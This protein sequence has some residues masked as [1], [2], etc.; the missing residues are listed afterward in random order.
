M[1]V[2]EG[3]TA[4]LQNLDVLVV[5]NKIHRVAKDIEEVGTWEVEAEI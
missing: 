3:V 4:A 1:V 2:F 5:R